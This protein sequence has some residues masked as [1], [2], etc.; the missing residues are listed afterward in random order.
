MNEAL[1]EKARQEQQDRA[2]AK[3]LRIDGGRPAVP[4]RRVAWRKA[5]D[6][7]I[8]RR[9]WA[10]QDRV[11]LGEVTLWVGHAGI[12][13]SLAA[14]WLS[15]QVTRG[16]LA[17]E[18]CGKPAPVMYLATEDSWELSLAPRLLAAGADMDNVLALHTE[19]LVGEDIA[20]GTLSLA[21]DIPS[22]RQAVERTGAR[23]IVLDAL[24]SAMS[25]F[26]LAKQGIV[27]SLLEPLSRLA[28]DLAVAVV[29]VAHFRKSG[30]TEPLLM[31]SGSAE[32]G[33]VVRSAVGFA[34]DPDA[35]DGSCVM[36]VIKSNVASL[37]TPS[38]RYVVAPA[39]VRAED[40]LPTEVGR[41]EL[42][43]ESDQDVSALLNHGP[44]SADEQSERSESRE[45][46]MAY[47]RDCGGRAEAGD[48]I[49]AAEAAG[50][51]KD[52]VKKA[53][54]KIGAKTEKVGFAG[55]WEWVLAEGAGE[56]AVDARDVAQAPPAP[57]GTFQTSCAGVCGLPLGDEPDNQ[58]GFH[59][60]C[61]P[62]GRQ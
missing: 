22:L 3:V 10:W 20:E 37:R 31:I 27:R 45:W 58:G 55:R 14:A 57:S 11:P 51:S 12:G 40:G 7:E 4:V 6:F 53:R 13:K 54:V 17:G 5:S 1:K 62:D 30:G 33:Q 9:E 8:K 18:L 34:R 41:F 49:R 2:A 39:S 59:A 47:L 29:G 50:L 48:V 61:H 21:V 32:F 25:G 43:G 26:D 35:E 24:L 60:E 28:Q 38:L 19:T 23:V 16:A 44:V 42:V 52:K 36:S 46:L 15:A 56:G